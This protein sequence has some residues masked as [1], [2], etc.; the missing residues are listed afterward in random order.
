MKSIKE[1]Q[2]RYR[3][4]YRDKVQAIKSNIIRAELQRQI[5]ERLDECEKAPLHTILP[6]AEDIDH[7][8]IAEKIINSPEWEEALLWEISHEV[9]L[10]FDAV[11]DELTQARKEEEEE[12]RFVAS[13]QP[14]GIH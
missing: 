13:H 10:R 12:R 9:D 1:T 6:E 4:D 3:D 5:D 2:L 14:T 8:E 7:K 11:K